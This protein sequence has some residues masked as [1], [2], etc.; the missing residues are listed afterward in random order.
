[1]R[2]LSLFQ[3]PHATLTEL[4]PTQ[5]EAS[6]PADA[7]NEVEVEPSNNTPFKSWNSNSSPS[8]SSRSDT[9]SPHTPPQAIESARPTIPFTPSKRR[10]S[11]STELP[12]D[13]EF[14]ASNASS[15]NGVY[16]PCSGI[17]A[18]DFLSDE[19]FATLFLETKTDLIFES[20]RPREEKILPLKFEIRE[21][22]DRGMTYRP[23]KTAELNDG[24]FLRITSV[25]ENQD[26]TIFLSGHRLK[27]AKSCGSL[28]PQKLNELVWIV[29]RM[30][31]NN[32]S[33]ISPQ[34]SEALLTMA[35]R[36]RNVTFTNATYPD[37]SHETA[38]ET[39]YGSNKDAETTGRLFCR[40]KWTEVLRKGKR[41][42]NGSIARLTSEEADQHARLESGELRDQWRGRGKTIPGGSWTGEVLG[43]I[44]IEN[45][46]KFGSCRSRH[47]I[48]KRTFA[49]AFCGC[50]GVSCGAQQ[51]GYH[52]EWAYDID[53]D[54]IKTYRANYQQS[55]TSCYRMSCDEF[56]ARAFDDHMVD[57]LHL[58]PPCQS[59]SPANTRGSDASREERQAPLFSVLQHLETI[60]PRIATMEETTG[61]EDRWKEFLD[62]ALNIFIS[63]GYSV[64]WRV[65]ELW[66]HGIPQRRKR[67]LITSAG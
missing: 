54:K 2:R 21:I 11:G 57:H 12:D 58:S 23:G 44:D 15:P 8:T 33:D 53:E 4:S 41:S 6:L 31:T 43:S 40:W 66:K 20:D 35:I 55:G 63:V 47:T 65:E 37:F 32:E 67:L 29:A 60:K 34:T 51:A 45:G 46:P 16:V 5:S 48:R 22:H 1:M 10:R 39:T 25:L 18:N 52:V 64:E 7:N 56:L 49:D 61:L 24:T 9:G 13:P 26:G 59:F 28:F 14:S 38:F 3:S 19:Q 27:R 36:V 30:E 62:A 17:T 50:G 42:T